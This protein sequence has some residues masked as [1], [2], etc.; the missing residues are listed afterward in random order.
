[1]SMRV[2]NQTATQPR[3]RAPEVRARQD[4]APAASRIDEYEYESDEPATATQPEGRAPEVR[5]RRL[6]T[7]KDGDP[8]IHGQAL[9]QHRAFAESFGAKT[10][11]LIHYQTKTPQ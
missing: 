5:R 8:I 3:G 11:Y 10:S 9:R 6:R 7:I 2:T 1:M 4:R